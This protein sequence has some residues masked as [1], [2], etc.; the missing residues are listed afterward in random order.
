MSEIFLSVIV[1]VYNSAKYIE[2]CIESLLNQNM[3][4][5]EYEIVCIDDGS[6]DQSVDLIEK[7]QESGIVR[8]I[9]QKNAGVSTARNVGIMNSRGKYIT[10][11]DSDDMVL[12]GTY[13]MICE[14]L[15]TESVDV[16]I[17]G[18]NMGIQFNL[19]KNDQ[20]FTYRKCEKTALS[21]V[22]REII[23][24]QLIIDNKLLFNR[25]IS[26]G[27]DYWFNHQLAC[28]ANDYLISDYKAYFY[29]IYPN[30]SS[31]GRTKQVF[32]KK[33]ESAV[34]IAYEAH[35]LIKDSNLDHAAKERLKDVECEYCAASLLYGLKC[36]A[37]GKILN[38]LRR[39]GLYPFERRE[40][41][42][43]KSK[44]LANEL[45]KHLN[46]P[47][48]LRCAIVV[49]KIVGIVKKQ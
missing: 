17:F 36:N 48:I 12:H 35:N 3:N 19:E 10:F 33:A 37:G 21:C 15:K 5:S 20:S 30:S 6:T 18:R 24:K 43:H 22:W 4:P 40:I 34:Q 25:M 29:R 44:T 7:Y 14:V 9:K 38:T 2:E 41:F 16:F 49:S 45:M 32:L 1:P 47:V 13:E 26:M 23:R 8:L 31:Q 28:Y 42:K 11:V 46:N 39:K 27:E